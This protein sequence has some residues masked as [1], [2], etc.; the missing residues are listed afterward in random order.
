[1]ENIEAADAK[2]FNFKMDKIE[3]Y[4]SFAVFLI[5]FLSFSG[6]NGGF[7]TLVLFAVTIVIMAYYFIWY[8][9]KPAYVVLE[10]ERITVHP[11]LFYKPIQVSRD[12]VKKVNVSDKKIEL[13]Y[14]DSKTISVYAIMLDVNGWKELS[15]YLKENMG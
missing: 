4:V 6:K 15:T 2:E 13:V 9:K 5:F 8:R 14:G 3:R 12:S 1:M 11:P 10:N 7:W